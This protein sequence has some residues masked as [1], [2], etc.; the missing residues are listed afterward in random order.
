MRKLPVFV[1]ALLFG[2]TSIGCDSAEDDPTD[3]ELFV[4]TWNL[5]SLTDAE[6]DKTAGFA[7]IANSFRAELDSDN[8]AVI[9]VDYKA[10]T[11]LENRVIPG[12]YNV[13]EAEKA[14]ILTPPAGPSVPFDY[15]ILSESRIRLSAASAF[16]NGLFQTDAYKGTV[17]ITIE[18]AS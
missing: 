18:K 17:V 14:F 10:E 5:V 2:L 3:A 16:I 4:G 11:G 13:V 6:G 15:E 8:T 1:F 9:T 12:T 7:A